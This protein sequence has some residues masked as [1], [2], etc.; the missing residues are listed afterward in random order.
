MFSRYLPISNYST[1]FHG[2][3]IGTVVWDPHHVVYV[4][5]FEKIQQRVARW[6]T[7]CFDQYSSV[8][9]MLSTLKW[10]PLAK[11]QEISRL[12]LFHKIMYNNYL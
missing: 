10:P 9:T 1:A 6:V 2:I 4:N 3:C 11:H 8:S 12:S 5:M 7:G